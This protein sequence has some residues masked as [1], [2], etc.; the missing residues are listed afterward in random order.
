MTI[1]TN[2]ELY[3]EIVERPLHL[4]SSI[5]YDDD[6]STM[7]DSTVGL[8]LDDYDSDD[9]TATFASLSED[10]TDGMVFYFDDDSVDLARVR[11][12]KRATT[13]SAVETYD[14]DSLIL[15]RNRGIVMSSETRMI[16]TSSDTIEIALNDEAPHS[17]SRH[18]MISRRSSQGSYRMD[19]FDD[20]EGMSELILPLAGTSDHRR[21][22]IATAGSRHRSFQ[23]R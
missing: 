6:M 20:E 17:S 8:D 3:I 15:A 22:G 14:D 1:Q 12:T 19:C 18:A 13:P 23:R 11:A 16:D 5:E 9:D 7:D 10:G 21:A 4:A 2:Y